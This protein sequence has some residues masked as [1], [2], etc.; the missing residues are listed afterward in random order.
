MS[1]ESLCSAIKDAL[2]ELKRAGESFRGHSWVDRFQRILAQN[3]KNTDKKYSWDPEVSKSGRA[4]GDR[5]DIFGRANGLPD[6]IIEIDATR[7]DQVA[8][9]FLSRLALWGLDNKRNIEYVAILYPD[10]QKGKKTCEKFIRYGYDIIQKINKKSNIT[11]I[12]IDPKNNDD[13][14]VLD[15]KGSCRFDVKGHDCKSMNAAAAEALSIYLSKHSVKYKEL[16]VSWGRFVSD[17]RGK[18]RYKPID[19]YTNDSPPKQVYSYTQFRKY[20]ISS[21]WEDFVRMCKEAKIEIVQKRKI[22]DGTIA[23]RPFKYIV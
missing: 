17:S 14:E 23:A 12:F 13:I 1:I 15:Y 19:S 20:G 10:T 18:S 6:W 11:G 7:A 22:Y 21:Y 16:K 4:E 3:L 8:K 2:D 9:K 5:V